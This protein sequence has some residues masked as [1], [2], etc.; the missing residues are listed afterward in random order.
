MKKSFLVLVLLA[1]AVG[2]SC[3][4]H[5]NRKTKD[6]VNREFIIKD[7]PDKVV[8]LIPGIME[9]MNKLSLQEKVIGIGTDCK[10][11][12]NTEQIPI[13]G[14]FFGLDTNALKKNKPDYVFA[15]TTLDN[16]IW[17]WFQRN[18]ISLVL[19]SYPTKIEDTYKAL[20]LIGEILGEKAKTD[21]AIAEYKQEVKNIVK[22][23]STQK[24]KGYF[25]IRFNDRFG[26]DVAASGNHIIGNLMEIAG[27]DNVAKNN[28]DMIF[29]RDS[30][31]NKDPEYIFMDKEMLAAFANTTPYSNLSA[32][33]NNKL[34]GID[35]KL[36][37]AYTPRYIEAIKIISSAIK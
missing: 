25:S 14:S 32:T 2:L 24:P 10:G 5:N 12:E 17:D 16:D 6:M 8:C 15:M 13:V 18:D 11:I 4:D 31:V 21:K 28:G 9:W 36:L 20:N 1:I 19:F 34:V 23:N 30:I 3:T 7:K 35:M 22:N 26:E 33:K 29:H 27:V 37:T